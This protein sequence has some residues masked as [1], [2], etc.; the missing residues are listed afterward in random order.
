ME[1]KSEIF[2]VDSISLTY[3]DKGKKYINNYGEKEITTN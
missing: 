2:Y 1:V 3:Y